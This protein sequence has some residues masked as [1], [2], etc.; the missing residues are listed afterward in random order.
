MTTIVDPLFSTFRL[1]TLQLKNRIVMAPM[2]RARAWSGIP[3]QDTASYYR[4]R[5][6]A[7]VGLVLSEGTVVDRPSA[8]NEPNVPSF[9][10]D[11]AL[12]GWKTV[13]DEV[14]AVGGRIGPQLWHVG[15]VRHANP[16]EPEAEPFAVDGAIDSPSGLDGNDRIVGEPMTEESISDTIAAFARAAGTARRLGFDV[17]EIHAAHG[18]LIDQFFWSRTNLRNDRFGGESLSQR[19][20]F[21][22][23]LV[24]AVRADVGP[25]LPVIVRVSQWKQQDY[26]ARLVHSPTEVERW[27]GP[28]VDAGADA[29]HCSQRRFW[30]PEFPELDGPN[31]LNLAGWVKKLLGCTT[32][33]VGSVGLSSDLF[34]MIQTGES[35]KA[36][37]LDHL[38]RRLER[39][40][41][42]LVAVGRA[43][44][45][46]AHWASKVR[47]EDLSRLKGFSLESLNEYP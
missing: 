23:E 41:F 38:V 19:S 20:S 40:E 5:A 32:I 3:N 42:D 17:I 28:I 12:A 15:G 34:S 18:Y 1:K 24:K 14:H 29:I 26:S 46:D 22:V 11:A 33:T 43:L 13:V 4:R 6:E 25:D 37:G 36:S 27:L 8:R 9:H 31:G 44:I 21:A 35:S 7:G 45:A 2:T 39:G 16:A 30:E 10:G 47:T